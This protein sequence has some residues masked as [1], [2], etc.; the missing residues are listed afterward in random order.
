MLKLV[1]GYIRID[2]EE[3]MEEISNILNK[4]SCIIEEEAADFIIVSEYD[5]YTIDLLYLDGYITEEDYME[6]SELDN[7]KFYLD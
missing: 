7:I 2:S 1:T 4:S 5:P 3:T 6:I